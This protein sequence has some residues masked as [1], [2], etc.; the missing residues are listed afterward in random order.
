MQTK[1]KIVYISYI[2]INMNKDNL[3]LTSTTVTKHTKGLSLYDL[4]TEISSI[5]M[6]IKK[7]EQELKFEQIPQLQKELLRLKKIQWLK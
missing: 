3:N 4:R 1:N 5:Q 6:K 2:F 7:S